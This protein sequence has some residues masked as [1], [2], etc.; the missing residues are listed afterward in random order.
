MDNDI[1][2]MYQY[3]FNFVI[4]SELPVGLICIEFVQDKL[5]LLL[6]GPVTSLLYLCDIKIDVIG[7]EAVLY[8]CLGVRQL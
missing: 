6:K 2:I 4:P 7:G 3:Y 5:R 8:A 1:Y